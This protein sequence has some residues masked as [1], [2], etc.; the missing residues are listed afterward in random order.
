MHHLN[1]TSIRLESAAADPL[2]QG[3]EARLEALSELIDKELSGADIDEAQLQGFARRI[4]ADVD[5]IMATETHWL[6]RARCGV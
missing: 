1:D 4:T 5:A 2:I 3:S 6:R